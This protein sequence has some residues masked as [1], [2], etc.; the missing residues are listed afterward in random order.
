M[1]N[2]SLDGLPISPTRFLVAAIFNIFSSKEERFQYRISKDLLDLY[3]VFFSTDLPCHVLTLK[4][5]V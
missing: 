2:V 5:D 4:I 1:I 3:F